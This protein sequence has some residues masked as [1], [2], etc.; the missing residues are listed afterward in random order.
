MLE[1]AFSKHARLV[2]TEHRDLPK[3]GWE[4]VGERGGKLWEFY[5]GC[6]IG[7]HVTDVRIAADGISFWIKSAPKDPTQ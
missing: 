6:R 3:Q 1:S 7:H 2:R 4:H 5:R